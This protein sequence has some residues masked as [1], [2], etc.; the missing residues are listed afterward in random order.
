METLYQWRI[1]MITVKQLRKIHGNGLPLHI[2][3]QDYI[4]SI[5]LE[6]LYKENVS[7]VFK[8]GTYLKHAFGLDRFS[9]DIDFTLKDSTDP[10]KDL[11]SAALHLSAYG[12]DAEID[13]IEERNISYNSRLMYR[14]PLY[15]GTK[16]SMGNID[17]DI[18]KRKDI[19]LPPQWNRLFF[20]YPE[21]RVVNVLGLQK[22]E[23]LAEK[24]R[25]LCLRDKA[26]DLYDV[27]FLVNQD[28][29]LDKNMFEQKMM[30]TKS[31]AKIQISTTESKWKE[32]LSILL[33]NPPNY[34]DVKKEIIQRLTD[35]GFL[36]T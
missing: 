31:P 11:K 13:N 5:F 27:W 14:G 3:E 12:I 17:I 25:A 15:Q 23:I 22:K 26:R 20:K 24:L 9:E 1:T 7:L 18:S 6:Q 34:N 32:D 16:I 4:Q 2:L 30:I 29:A 28:V 36:I 35:D 19:F 33:I 21:T 8:G 10:I